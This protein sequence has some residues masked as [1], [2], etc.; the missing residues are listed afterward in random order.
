[1]LARAAPISSMPDSDQLHCMEVWGGNRGI[2]NHFCLPG[3]EIW[4]YSK[5]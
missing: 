2:E 5:P 1:M 4:L 3:L